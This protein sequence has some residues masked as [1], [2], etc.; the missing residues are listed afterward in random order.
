MRPV[1]LPVLRI[2]QPFAASSPATWAARCWRR[3]LL[4]T[5][6]G[7]LAASAVAGVCVAGGSLTGGA[8]GEDDW[9]ADG[10]DDVVT[11]AGVV[12][13][14]TG[15]SAT[16]P[17]AG[18]VAEG[19]LLSTSRSSTTATTAVTAASGGIALRISCDAGLPARWLD[20]L[21]GGGELTPRCRGGAPTG[22][23]AWRCATG[24]A[25]SPASGRRREPR[26]G[27]AAR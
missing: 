26:D 10:L 7:S 17:G 12:D 11:A 5:V 16:A 1:K 15:C 27:P 23:A 14:E 18:P 2:G 13:D 8:A 6:T 22:P 21:V 19:R 4:S 20:G 3:E 25:V 24:A 9:A